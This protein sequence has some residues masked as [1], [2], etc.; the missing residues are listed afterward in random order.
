MRTNRSVLAVLLGLLFAASFA[1]GQD[2]PIFPKYQVL[3][4]I[5][6]PPGASSNVDYMNSTQIGSSHSIVSD[7]SS[8]TTQTQSSTTSFNLFGLGYS[9]TSLTSDAWTAT[10]QDMSS[11][12]LT[13]TMGNGISVTGPFSGLG[14]LH[15]A[16][17]IVLWLNPVLKTTL[18]PPTG[19]G[20]VFPIQWSGFMFNGCDLNATQYP[21]NFMQLINGC[22]TNGFPGP[23]IAYIPVTCLKNPYSQSCSGYLTQTSR[24]WDLSA[25]GVDSVTKVPL[26]PGLTVQDYADIL[27]TDPLVTQTLVAN[28]TQPGEN[29]Y[30]DPCHPAY[31][32]N[33]DPN[34]QET[35]PDSKMFALP[36]MGKWPA[37]YCGAAG[38]PM[39]RFNYFVSG[40][41]IQY[42]KPQNGQQVTSTGFLDTNAVNAHGQQSTDTHNHSFSESASL[43][44][45]ASASYGPVGSSKDGGGGWSISNLSGGFSFGITSGTGYSWTDTQT[46]AKTI[47]HVQAKSAKYSVTGPKPSD[48]WF[49]PYQYNVYQDTLY[50]TFA[51]R[52]PSRPVNTVLITAGK[53]SPIGIAFSGSTNFGTVTV[54]KKSALITVTLTNNSPNQMTMQS[55]SLSFSDLAVDPGNTLVRVSSFVAPSASDGCAN[56][57]LNAAA[58]CMV[59][60]QF[61][62]NL[63]AAPD[64]VQASYPIAAYVIAAANELVPVTDWHAP[65]CSVGTLLFWFAAAMGE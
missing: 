22:D 30:T 17:I 62:P 27:R 48:S 19:G 59:K 54:G 50:G 10:Y 39:E 56:K 63:N 58:T 41:L 21:Y 53:T 16:D 64:A 12:T 29:V 6:A 51:F 23:D 31:G 28:N 57:V 38:M 2:R 35:L 4:V 55:P 5:Y 34:A 37:N 14:V 43:S 25:W 8:T 44:F 11:E 47:T 52:D 3:G 9:D 42:P 49:G 61:A 33:F 36:Y 7:S 45:S 26:G 15:D 32:I 13:T 1:G 46:Y 18:L 20:T 65:A 24:S 60:I 40:G